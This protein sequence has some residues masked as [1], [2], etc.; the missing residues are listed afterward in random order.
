MRIHLKKTDAYFWCGAVYIAIGLA[1]NIWWF[2]HRP[3]FPYWIIFLSNLAPGVF[4]VGIRITNIFGKQ[5][6]TII[7]VLIGIIAFVKVYQ[8]ARNDCYLRVDCDLSRY[9]KYVNEDRAWWPQLMY[10]F[11][12]RIPVHAE[13]TAFF[14]GRLWDLTVIQ[15]R[16]TLPLDEVRDV[17]RKYRSLAK[18]IVNGYNGA[19][20]PKNAYWVHKF[21]NK[22]N[23]RFSP[24]PASFEVMVLETNLATTELEQSV[25]WQ[26][27]YSSG[28]AI[29]LSDR[30]I[31][32]W[33]SH[34]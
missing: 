34:P 23:T 9:E 2:I 31:I 25:P 22:E 11:P 30:E 5:Y 14:R 3:T 15:L 18:H 19:H 10:H 17:Q 28:V 27:L 26:L 1:A 24:L 8:L 7:C 21:R 33:S 6:F 12:E 4:L 13:N 16:C 32:Y 29:N 20:V